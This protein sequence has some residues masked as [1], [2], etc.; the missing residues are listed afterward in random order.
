MELTQEYRNFVESIIK[1]NRR[2]S[3][4]EELFDFIYS[5]TIKRSGSILTTFTDMANSEIYINK[6]VN[7]VIFEALKNKGNIKKV[8]HIPSQSEENS[9]TSIKSYDLDEF[10]EILLDIQDP[11]PNIQCGIIDKKEINEIKNA[12][13]AL[14]KQEPDKK[15]Y[16]IFVMRYIDGIVQSKIAADIKIS[17][18][19]VSR[20][21]SELT[22]KVAVAL[23]Q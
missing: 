7:A 4:N 21:L 11:T 14:N 23:G 12:V 8:E 9:K 3:G 10:G 22:Q 1:N 16:D 20:R 13:L 15:Y 19:E 18:N 6:I 2:F 5:E 17:E